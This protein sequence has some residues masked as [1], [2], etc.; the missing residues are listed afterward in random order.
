ME[1]KPFAERRVEFMQRYKALIDELHV[2]F[3]TTP[4]FIPVIDAGGANGW[5]QILKSELVDTT[6]APVKSPIQL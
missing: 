1:Q 4:T 5:M 6:E 2:D 3:L